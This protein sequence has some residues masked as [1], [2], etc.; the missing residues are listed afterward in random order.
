MILVDATNYILY[1]NTRL[2]LLSTIFIVPKMC[3][4]FKQPIY[5]NAIC[6]NITPF[7]YQKMA[8]MI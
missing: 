8:G 2:K 6:M 4:K 5:Y 7:Q 3:R 1:E